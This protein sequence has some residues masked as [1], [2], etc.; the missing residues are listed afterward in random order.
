MK[1]PPTYTLHIVGNQENPRG[2][3]IGYKRVLN[4]SMRADGVRYMAWQQF[5]RGIFSEV[6][7]RHSVAATAGRGMKFLPPIVIAKHQY[8]R[9]ELQIGWKDETHG[10]QDNI[11]KGIADSL[12][13][14]DK[15]LE[16][17]FSATHG[18]RGFVHVEIWILD[19]E[20]SSPAKKS[21]NKSPP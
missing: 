8:A 2:N 12:F 1:T 14:N 17:S 21:K 7:G 6:T 5:V 10:D 4:H 9:M 20:E 3:P 19:R 18:G 15:E 11:F 16:G 13:A